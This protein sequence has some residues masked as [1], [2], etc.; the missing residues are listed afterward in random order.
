MTRGATGR[1]SKSKGNRGSRGPTT[2]RTRS[3]DQRKARLIT[4]RK[5]GNK[6]S[7]RIKRRVAEMARVKNGDR[8]KDLQKR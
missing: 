2:K 1:S 5:N 6:I 3:K 4:K 8:K 7:K